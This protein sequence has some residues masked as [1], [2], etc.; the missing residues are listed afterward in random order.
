[1]DA[2]ALTGW[3]AR[4]HAGRQ[5]AGYIGQGLKKDA[6]HDGRWAPAGAVLQ[7][8]RHPNSLAH[9]ITNVMAG[10]MRPFP[11]EMSAGCRRLISG[12]LTPDPARRTT[13]AVGAVMSHV[14]EVGHHVYTSY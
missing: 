4:R 14:K 12:L 1:M 5:H 2:H 10:R 13:L 9:T 11:E 8:P 3:L 6:L 7:D